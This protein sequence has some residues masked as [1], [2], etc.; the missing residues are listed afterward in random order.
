[1]WKKEDEKVN[2]S[3]HKNHKSKRKYINWID[4][5]KREE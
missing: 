5:N 1:M 2:E 4:M 3:E